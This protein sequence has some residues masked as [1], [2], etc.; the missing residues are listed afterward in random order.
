ME[1]LA[2]QV[3]NTESRIVT[4][5]F[6]PKHPEVPTLEDY[7]SNPPNEW[8]ENFPKLSWE[9]GK[10]VKSHL[11]PSTLF[12]YATD[13]NYPDMATV[14]DIVQDIKQG[15]D[16]MCRGI[17]L[18]PSTSSNAPSAYEHGSKVTDS[19][20]DG[21]KKKIMIGPMEENEIPFES[22][23]TSGI[24]VKLKPDN[25]ARI[26][27]NMSQG[28]PY[29]V[30]EGID[31]DNFEVYMSSTVRWL[32]ALHLAGQGCYI[33]KMDWKAAYKNLRVQQSDVRLQFFK[34]LGKYFAELCL[35][36]GSVSSVGLYDRLARLVLHIA[37]HYCSILRRQVARHLDDVVAAG[38]FDETN[39]FY[40]KY[41]EVTSDIGVELAEVTDP[42][43]AFAP[44]QEGRVFGIEYNT[45]EFTWWL[46]EDKLGYILRSLDN[47]IENNVQKVKHMKSLAGKIMD[48]KLMVPTGKYNVGQIL[49]FAG[50]NN[51][52]PDVEIEVS[53]WCRAEAY[54]WRTMLPFCGRRVALPDPD[55]GL[56]VC[57]VQVYT[58]SAGGSLSAV[59]AG[60][61]AVI[62]PNWWTYAKWGSE[63][64]SGKRYRDG[65]K[66]SNKMSALELIPPLAV[67]CSAA[68]HIRGQA[69]V[70][71][72]DNSGS[73]A[74][75]NKG[76]S[77]S[78]ML[79]NTLIVAMSQVAAALSCTVTMRKVR[80][81][82]TMEACAADSLSKANFFKFRKD[83]PDSDL[84]P[85]TL[86]KA[87]L[88]WINKPE[89]DRLLGQKLLR[90]MANKTKIVGYS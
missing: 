36:F 14:M 26:I 19:I 77:T 82:S 62:Y 76:W 35:I 28:F 9:D 20:V 57:A 13:I 56:P 54:F 70:I 11:N 4:K 42:D 30:N 5:K 43:K 47:V 85:A 66:I 32:R 40:L 34:W 17:N 18:C 44:C 27:L 21:I 78:C 7:S 3:G 39:E 8:W 67:L 12:K 73:V 60:M 58:D 33:T 64:N 1:S 24:M 31:N 25:S 52:S 50:G 38:T 46:R 23:K 83:M 81:C 51:D 69:V 71:H 59:G 55:Q 16:T 84:A 68:E 2:A 80:R 53:N 89:E 61:G 63:I 88:T 45:V 15:C 90:E 72:V 48:V 79:C 22:I 41:Q 49:K 6:K 10:A 74:M 65:K 75:F 37:L 86:P 87:L 29:S